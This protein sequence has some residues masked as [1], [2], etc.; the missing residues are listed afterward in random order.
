ADVKRAAPRKKKRKKS[1][2]GGAPAPPPRRPWWIAGIVGVLFAALTIWAW[3]ARPAPEPH[4]RQGNRLYAE[5]RFRDALGEYEGAP[6]AGPRNAGVHLDRG[7]ARYR[8]S[9]PPPDG[10]VLPML[11]P[12][13]ASPEGLTQAQDEMRTAARG[14]STGAAEEVEPFMRARAAYD[15]ANT[16]FS[17]HQWDHAIEAYKESLRL[18][19]GWRD[20]AWN[21]ELARRLRELERNPPDAGQDASHDAS[22]DVTP[23]DAQDSGTDASDSGEDSGNDGGMDSGGNDGGGQDSGGGDSGQ[24]DSGSDGGGDSSARPDA[25]AS[26]AGAAGQDAGPQDAQAPRSM[27]PLDDL[28]RTVRSLQN[29]LLRRRGTTPRSPD[30]DR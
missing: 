28:D 18:H 23:P 16:F 21:M 1:R 19:P 12:D 20:A 15:L 9:V 8:V 7:L 3:P 5:R 24:G 4:V 13:A 17:L 26:D 6:G 10:S 11:G 2:K 29:E 27:A 30:D 14:G 22:Q 25:G